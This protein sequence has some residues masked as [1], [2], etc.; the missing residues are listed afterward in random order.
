MG[1]APAIHRRLQEL[2]VGGFHEMAINSRVFFM[3]VPI[4]FEFMVTGGRIIGGKA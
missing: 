1:Q 2:S 4:A 3:D